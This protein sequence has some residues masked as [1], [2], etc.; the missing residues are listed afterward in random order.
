MKKLFGALVFLVIYSL[1]IACGQLAT[2]TPTPIPSPS[3]T[4][5]A[6]I[7][8]TPSQTATATIEVTP[9]PIHVR[10]TLIPT[11]DS[12]VLPELIKNAFS[13][14]TFD[15]NGY[16]AQRITG[17]TSGFGTN[18]WYNY[19][20]EYVWLDTNHILL[21][22]G[23]GQINGPEG[24]WGVLNMVPQPVVMNLE[25]GSVWLLPV[26]ISSGR[27]CNHVFWSRDLGILINSGIYK[28]TPAVFTH[29]FDGKNLAKYRGQFMQV[30][31]S[32]E[33]ILLDNNLLID[34]RT[35]SRTMLN[36]NLENDEGPFGGFYWT[37]DETRIYR[38]C[39]YYAD[40][41]TGVSHRFERSDFQDANGTHL[42]ARGLWFHQGEWVRDD[43]YF[44]VHWL[45][46]D[47]GPV[48]YQPLFDPA[49]KLFYDLWK[50]AGISPDLTWRYNDVSPDGNY[51][52]IIGF[53]RSYLVNLTTFESQHFTY[54]FPNSYTDVN[55][56]SDSNFAWFEIYDPDA[57][58]TEVKILSIA[59]MKSNPVLV[60]PQ[61]ETERLWHPHD[62]VIAYPSQD[63]N[64]LIFL[65]AATMSY[66]EL[67][68]K[69]QDSQ[70]IISNLIWSP[71]G[72]K[73]VF[74]TDDHVLWQ[75]DFPSL[76]DLEQIMASANT[77]SGAEWSP[78]GNSIAFV[79]GS[80]IYIV[81][82]IK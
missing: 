16:N 52:W 27:T 50:Q 15:L 49:T 44:L 26:D 30:S 73:L 76:E 47:D 56:S 82:T 60:T 57:K 69:D 48:R 34:L 22:P 65:D 8:P 63:K 81:D 42:D 10:P 39:Y 70:Y 36:W 59:D 72:D 40:L 25:T 1:L 23:A 66:R 74:I 38:C 17:W 7:V 53:E 55:W 77:I 12:A 14:Q 19:C 51:V 6:T 62:N 61:S 78:D 43:K 67:P 20:P 5:T 31:P 29:T 33:K 58:S 35:N 28:G 24:I 80:D 13:L 79:N 32:K 64:A 4:E 46:V 18:I 71:S 2:S 11:I 45:A 68:F 21:Y 3:M 75:V 9:G 41:T 54:S 37:S